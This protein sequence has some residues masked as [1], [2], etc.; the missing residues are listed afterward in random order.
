M[1]E[2][3]GAPVD[4]GCADAGREKRRKDTSGGADFSLGPSTLHLHSGVLAIQ[5]TPRRTQ[6][7][8]PF[9]H[10]APHGIRMCWI[11]W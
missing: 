5:V 10:T 7:G 3:L 6:A 4:G 8:L 2:A 9:V 11:L 1:V